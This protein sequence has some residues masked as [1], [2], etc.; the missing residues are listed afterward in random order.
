MRGTLRSTTELIVG[1][2][3]QTKAASEQLSGVSE[4]TGE[5][6]EDFTAGK[7]IY[8]WKWRRQRRTCWGGVGGTVRGGGQG[9]GGRFRFGVGVGKGDRLGGGEDKEFGCRNGGGK[10]EGHS[11]GSQGGQGQVQ[12][13]VQF[14]CN[15]GYQRRAGATT[16]ASPELWWSAKRLS[17]GK[18]LVSGQERRSITILHACPNQ[19]RSLIC[20]C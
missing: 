16:D 5:K 15:Q 2:L 11:Q 20:M 10:G 13:Q 1:K 3:T 17:G 8:Q 7:K 6:E 4:T 9:V 18:G 14:N 19:G 12:V